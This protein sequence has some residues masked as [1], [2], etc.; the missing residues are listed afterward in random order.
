VSAC[1]TVSRSAIPGTVFG[2]FAVSA[3]VISWRGFIASAPS[4]R[5]IKSRSVLT[6]RPAR[7]QWHRLRDSSRKKIPA[8]QEKPQ[9]M[10]RDDCRV[11]V[12]PRDLECGIRGVFSETPTRRCSARASSRRKSS[13]S[14]LPLDCA[15]G[16][17]PQKSMRI[18]RRSSKPHRCVGTSFIAAPAGSRPIFYQRHNL[19]V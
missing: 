12:K 15:N 3:L 4:M 6:H 9:S 2:G 1:P 18:A 14:R 8:R 11:H 5:W 16:A 7:L 10:T 19:G 17:A 13:A